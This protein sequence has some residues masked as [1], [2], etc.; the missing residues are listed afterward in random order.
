MKRLAFAIGTLLTVAGLAT[1][2]ATGAEKAEGA[3]APVFGIKIS[4]GYRDWK[5]ISVA[6][7]EGN[8]NDI[9]AIIGK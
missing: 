8:L 5:L 2:Q 3:A 1:Y 9:R 7:E 4:P 6:H